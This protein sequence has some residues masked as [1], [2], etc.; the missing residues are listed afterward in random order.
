MRRELDRVEP[1]RMILRAVL[2]GTMIVH[3]VRHCRTLDG[4]VRWLASIGFRQ[5]RAQAAISSALEVGAGTALVT[6]LATPLAAS[7]VVGTMAVAGHTVHRPN[8]FFV[9]DEGWEYVALVAAGATAL[10]ALGLALGAAFAHLTAFW[11]R[12]GAS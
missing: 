7:A 1:A 2:G 6:G 10:V 9:V 4:T 11:T 3:G 8:G 5:A 12:P